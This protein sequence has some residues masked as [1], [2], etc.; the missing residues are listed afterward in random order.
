VDP[1]LQGHLHELC[2]LGVEVRGLAQASDRFGIAERQGVH[3]LLVAS[4]RL[5]VVKVMGK[6]GRLYN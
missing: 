4:P 2:R 6:V 5:A 1:A 3:R